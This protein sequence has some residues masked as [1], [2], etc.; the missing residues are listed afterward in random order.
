MQKPPVSRVR[1]NAHSNSEI[2]V[3]FEGQNLT[4]APSAPPATAVSKPAGSCVEPYPCIQ[5]STHP[6]THF[7]V[8]I[9]KKEL[10]L[11]E[12]CRQ[13]GHWSCMLGN[14]ASWSPKGKVAIKHIL[15]SHVPVPATILGRRC[16]LP[17]HWDCNSCKC[18]PIG[19]T[20]CLRLWSLHIPNGRKRF[21]AP[22]HWGKI[23]Y[24]I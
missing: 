13:H 22:D 12:S 19:H 21:L 7:Y 14:A 24:E 3:P 23:L 11:S 4:M 5:A 10:Q 2:V 18:L 17:K 1:R 8:D 9:R 16:S 6:P 20:G 15:S